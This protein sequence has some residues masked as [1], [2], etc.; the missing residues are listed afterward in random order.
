VRKKR[1][2]FL[3]NT[4]RGQLEFKL[5]GG[6]FGAWLPL[7]TLVGGIALL[8]VNNRLSLRTFWVA[9]FVAL[10]VTFLV[11][12]EKRNFNAIAVRGL[13]GPIFAVLCPCFLLAGILSYTL[14]QSGL[15]NGLL[16]LT[17]SMN[18]N[19]AWMPVISFFTAA[20]ISTACGTSNGTVASVTPIMFPLAIQIGCNPA[21]V[22]GAIIS[23][24]VFGD[25][26]SPISDTTITVVN[27]MEC[28]VGP[29]MS[30]RLKYTIFAGF[31]AAI[32]FVVF[33]FQTMTV[34]DVAPAVID[35]AYAKTL[36]ML[37]VPAVMVLLMIKGM[38]LI[39]TLIICNITGLAI[40]LIMGF[41]KIESL[42][43]V[44]GPI[45]S[46]IDGM[47]GIVIFVMFLFM[48]LEF[49]RA[50]GAFDMVIRTVVHKCK[51]PRQTELAVVGVTTCTVF[52][53]AT[54]SP[55]MVLV[56]PMVKEL[57]A[58]NDI[59][60]RRA[61]N[62]LSGIACGTAGILPYASAMLLMFSLATE[63]GLLPEGFSPIQISPY[64]FHCIAMWL[65]YT[66]CAATGLW[67]KKDSS[68]FP[69]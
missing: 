4:N 5:Y 37:L 30:E 11:S 15:I 51:G 6:K 34:S 9:G 17:T 13:Q 59:D 22:L 40:C 18:L 45:I 53:T 47:V 20:I 60:R 38:E 21:L 27:I 35:P 26:L 41:I 46:G 2:V 32:L 65:T 63:T 23:G 56:G 28:D 36:L 67:R 12:Q 1:E 29:I 61:G 33:G 39:P 49:T 19:A 31:I 58:A 10:V 68:L 50:S 62:L 14:R 69:E 43:K 57:Y 16:W 52:C 48:L 44:D 55:A 66:I 64:S 7:T 42:I 54:N 8:T 25:N 24:S 3:L